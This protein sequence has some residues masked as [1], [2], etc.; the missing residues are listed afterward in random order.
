MKWNFSDVN[1]PVTGMG[2]P[3]GLSNGK[4][5]GPVLEKNSILKRMFNKFGH[6]N[7]TWWGKQGRQPEK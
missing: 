1:Q 7:F 5:R 6:Y 2:F 4:K 3:T